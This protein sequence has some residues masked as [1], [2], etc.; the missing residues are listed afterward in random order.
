MEQAILH[1]AVHS[2]WSS[3]NLTKTCRQILS[4]SL[5]PIF[6]I[7]W[8]VVDSEWVGSEAVK[9]IMVGEMRSRAKYYKEMARNA[10]EEG[11]SS[12]TSLNALIE[13]L[14]TYEIGLELRDFYLYFIFH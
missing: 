9:R 11:G 4:P 8:Q 6:L 5:C 12:Y 7:N 3:T 14:S 1:G 10:V 13:E 2:K